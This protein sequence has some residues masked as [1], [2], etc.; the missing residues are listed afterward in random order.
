MR[1]C[2]GCGVIAQARRK[3]QNEHPRNDGNRR[4]EI[5]KKGIVKEASYGKEKGSI[6][7]HPQLCPIAD[8]GRAS[9]RSEG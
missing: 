1:R 4:I 8:G 5:Q 7:L 2:H 3:Q 6:S 9:S